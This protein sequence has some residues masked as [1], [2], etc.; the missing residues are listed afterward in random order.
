MATPTRLRKPPAGEKVLIVI[1]AVYA[2]A[3][4]SLDTFRP[5]LHG[6]EGS[7]WPLSWY[8]IAT[9]G[10]QADNNGRVTQVDDDGPAAASGI[11]PGQQIDLASVKPD[12]RAINKFVYVAHGSAYTMPIV[13][14]PNAPFEVSVPAVDEKLE[15]WNA[16]TLLLAQFSGFFF[17]ALCTY[18]VWRS[19][20]WSTWGFFLYGIWFNSGQYFVWYAN[21]STASLAVF[22][23]LQVVF[24][25]LSMAGFLAFALYFPDEEAPPWSSRQRRVL[26]GGVFAVLLISGGPG[27]LNFL[28]GW[29][30]EIPYRV[31]YACTLVVYCLAAW[32]FLHNYH[33][34]PEQRPRMRWIVAAGLVGLPC[35]LLADVYE[36][37]NLFHYLPFG[38][39]DWVSDHDWVLNLLYACNVLLP[40]A[41]VYTALHHEVMSVRFGITRAVVLSTVFIVSVA[42]VD[43]LAKLPI[44]TFM[45]ERAA[46]KPFV[47]PLSFLFAV[48]LALLHN[49]LHGLVERACSPRWHRAQNQLREL[50]L[51]LMDDDTITLADVDR[52]LVEQTVAALWLKCAALFRRQPGEVFVLQTHVNW[53]EH[54]KETLPSDDVWFRSA[55]TAPA[56]LTDPDEAP[57]GPAVAVPVVRRVSRH[58]ASRVVLYG[59]HVTREQIDP[60]EMRVLEEVSRAAA[61]AYMRLDLEAASSAGHNGATRRPGDHGTPRDNM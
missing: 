21:L 7:A 23:A 34:L 28:L 51:R 43:A 18:L 19:A 44:E 33:R 35:F 26:L 45:E 42:A 54:I 29:R 14:G 8:P 11:R 59:H 20:T 38:I 17:I 13:S 37:T 53:P 49:P 10:F 6:G 27:F 2:I 16:T 15:G 61:L 48:V 50:S 52:A 31:Y 55:T 30:T 39:D 5:F 1:L 46:L 3:L 12:R 25:A 41:I 56:L 24:Q 32:I 4:I 36:A 9:L 47:V 40:A 58:A 57:G 60:D 22:D